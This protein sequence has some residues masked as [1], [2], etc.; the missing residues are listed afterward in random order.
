METDYLQFCRNMEPD[1]PS[2]LVHDPPLC[3]HDYPA[4][5]V[6]RQTCSSMAKVCHVELRRGWNVFK[7]FARNIRTGLKLS[8]FCWAKEARFCSVLF[9]P[10]ERRGFS[11]L[12]TLRLYL[13]DPYSRQKLRSTFDTPQLRV[14]QLA[15]VDSEPY[16]LRITPEALSSLQVIRIATADFQDQA[17]ILSTTN[18]KYFTWTDTATK[19]HTK[20]GPVLDQVRVLEYYG[21]CQDDL[22]VQIKFPLAI[23]TSKSRS[24]YFPVRRLGM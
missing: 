10:G 15:G 8:T 21:V 24:N 13:H 3:V 16:L 2:G 7:C 23:D 22:S 12:E 1:I 17:T 4:A 19:Q 11:L 14:I 6:T 9:P 5:K 18:P 20:D